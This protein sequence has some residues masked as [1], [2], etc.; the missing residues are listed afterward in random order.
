MQLTKS[1]LAALY[2][3]PE[4]PRPPRN[5]RGPNV[6]WEDIAKKHTGKSAKKIRE[7]TGICLNAIYKA[8]NEGK[9]KL[10]RRGSKHDWEAIGKLAETRTIAELASVTGLSEDNLRN[11]HKR[12]KFKSFIRVYDKED[13]AV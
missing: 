6:D 10:Q 7:A 9:I 3:E 13:K 8:A 5:L 2:P 11:A 12:G 4:E 1:D